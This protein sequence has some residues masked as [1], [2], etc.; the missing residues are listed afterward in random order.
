MIWNY[1][2]FLRQNT[3]IG[4]ICALSKIQTFSKFDYKK[5]YDILGQL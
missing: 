2:K 3:K 1:D 5:T 4:K